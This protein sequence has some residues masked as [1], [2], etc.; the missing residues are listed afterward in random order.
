MDMK[1][2]INIDILPDCSK[3]IHNQY[4]I[5]YKLLVFLFCKDYKFEKVGENN[6][7]R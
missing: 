1:T 3:C 7:K 6:S 2:Y 5:P 4:C